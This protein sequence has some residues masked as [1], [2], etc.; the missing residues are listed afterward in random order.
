VR[1]HERAVL[2]LDVLVE[3]EPVRSRL[4]EQAP[5]HRLAHLDPVAP[6]IDAV[7]LDEVEMAAMFGSRVE[8]LTQHAWRC[9]R[10]LL[11]HS[12]NPAEL[13]PARRGFRSS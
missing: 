9:H 4:R 1:E 8:G 5:E 12:E 2:V 3:P 11:R 13:R 6:Q 7:Q 10:G